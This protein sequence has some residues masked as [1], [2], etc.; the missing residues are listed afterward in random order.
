ME[1][2]IEELKEVVDR[3]YTRELD[4]LE[5]YFN[6]FAYA[7]EKENFPEL[8]AEL[9]IY[10]IDNLEKLRPVIEQGNYHFY[11]TT[12]IYNQRMWNDTKYKKNT[13]IKENGNDDLPNLNVMIDNDFESEE[14]LLR[15][16]MLIEERLAKIKYVYDKLP[17]HEKILFDKYYHRHN[18]M[19]KIGKEIGITQSGI[20]H[21]IVKIRNKI[22]NC[23]L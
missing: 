7:H 16:D 6:K 9:Y 22:K 4:K 23:K 12:W 5:K 17:L 21:Y 2:T 8:T 19:R 13:T 10:T 1:K 14:E 15:R 3:Y 11:A 20:F 18:S